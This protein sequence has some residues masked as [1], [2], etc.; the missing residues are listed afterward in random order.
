M[1]LLD[2]IMDVEDQLAGS[3]ALAEM[4]FFKEATKVYRSELR[5]IIESGDP[6]SQHTVDA[7][8][9]LQRVDAFI[10]FLYTPLYEEAERIRKREAEKAKDEKR[11]SKRVHR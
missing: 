7:L 5:S 1:K 6:H 4:E 11:K 2:D 9:G 3:N 8:V 10:N